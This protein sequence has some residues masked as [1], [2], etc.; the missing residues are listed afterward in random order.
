MFS[1]VYH[2][3]TKSLLVLV[4]CI[5]LLL[6]TMYDVAGSC[7]PLND[8]PLLLLVPSNFGFTMNLIPH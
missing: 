8:E 2:L 1:R 4:N 5:L 7:I 3:A 6:I